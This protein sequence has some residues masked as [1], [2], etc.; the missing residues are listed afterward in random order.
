LL[1]IFTIHDGHISAKQMI[2]KEISLKQGALHAMYQDQND[3]QAEFAGSRSGLA[4]PVGLR[5]RPDND[6]ICALPLG[7]GKDKFQLPGLVPAKGETRAVVTLDPYLRTTQRFGQTRTEFQRGWQMGN[8]NPWQFINTRLQFI[9]NADR[10]PL[11]HDNI[12][13]DL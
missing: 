3:I 12:L 11:G 1:Q 7:V 9:P 6:G 2:Q 8:W 13:L 4:A 5:S 10:I